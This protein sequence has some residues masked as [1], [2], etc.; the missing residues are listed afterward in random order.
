[1]ASYFST[2]VVRSSIDKAAEYKLHKDFGLYLKR[3]EHYFIAN[4]VENDRKVAVVLTVIDPEV[5]NILRDVCDPQLPKE[6]SY[7]DLCTILKK[8][9]S[10]CISVF[11]KRIDFY[12]AKQEVTESINDWYVKLKN[13]AM[14]CSFGNLLQE[15]L[16]DRF[17]T[18]LR[19]GPILDRLCEEEETRT[20]SKLLEIALKKKSTTQHQTC[21][22]VHKMGVRERKK[23]VPKKE[24][25]KKH[26]SEEVKLC[27]IC[28]KPNHKFSSSETLY[29]K[30]VESEVV[31]V[32][33]LDSRSKTKPIEV[34]VLVDNIPFKMELD[35]SA[36]T[37]VLSEF[38]YNKMLAHVK[39]E[40]TDVH[41]QTY[42]GSFITPVGGREKSLAGRDLL[43]TF[44]VGISLNKVEVGKESIVKQ[45]VK[46]CNEVFNEKLRKYNYEKI[47]LK[48][49]DNI[50]DDVVLARDY[51]NQNK[52][53]WKR[54]KVVKI[55]GNKTYSVRIIDKNAFWSRHVDQLF[56]V[57]DF[58][59]DN[60]LA[61]K[62]IEKNNSE[63]V[64]KK[65]SSIY[66][67]IVT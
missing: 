40:K 23:K 27:Y 46:E 37:S 42:D 39:L 58:D 30:V 11:R 20:L 67:R 19:T 35:T 50:T 22:S 16:K 24:I 29:K 60:L 36:G 44:N 15:K 17:L 51:R 57:G 31:Q 18:G 10:S 64:E 2:V 5:Y 8:Q 63:N 14:P 55:L 61:D 3:L 12:E 9:F 47:Y 41:L 52:K 65:K 13:H 1:M 53:E 56:D 6:K 34:N 45:L 59:E 62:E 26:S 66:F 7:T 25:S 28:G 4:S 54:G 49:K 33:S 43:T 21:L 48:L 38:L 32:F